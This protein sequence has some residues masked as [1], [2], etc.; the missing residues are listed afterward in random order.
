MKTLVLVGIVVVVLALAAYTAGIVALLRARRAN[1]KAL[2]LLSTGVV[3]DFVSTGCMVEAA[4]SSLLTPH[5]IVG[6][7]ALGGMIVLTVLAWRH[8]LRRGEE[9]LPD[10]LRT[11]ARFAYGWWVVAFFTGA[12]VA[13][14]RRGVRQAALFLLARL[15]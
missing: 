13:M 15:G 4:E 9:P 10:W 6:F 2:G 8:R 3:L 7:S 14:S 11:L 12:G 5:G 1:R